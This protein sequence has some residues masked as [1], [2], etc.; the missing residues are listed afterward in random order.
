[1]FDIE[2]LEGGIEKT[3]DT[4]KC[5]VKD[6]KVKVKKM[7]NKVKGGINS[8]LL[9]KKGKLKEFEKYFCKTHKIFISP[10]TFI[11]KNLEDN[12]LWYDE[13]DKALVK[14]ILKVKRVKYQLFYYNSEDA[15]S[16]N[17]FR[18][19][20]KNKLLNAF[21]TDLIN[22]TVKNTEVIYW[23]YSQSQNDVWSEL[24]KARGEFREGLQRSSEPDLIVK[25]DFA[26]F[27]IESKILAPN[28][29]DFN[30]SHTDEEKKERIAR[31]RRGNRFIS[32]SIETIINA[33]Y[34]QLMRFWLI[35]SWIAENNDLDFYLL[36]LVRKNDDKN[37]E[38]YFGKFLTLNERRLFKRI[39]WSDIYN[40]IS[41]NVYSGED[42]DKMLRYFRNKTIYDKKGRLQKAFSIP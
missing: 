6:C 29:V 23:S 31:Y 35:G 15:S 21:L 1:M 8:Y 37:I 27:F 42:K 20:E 3:N 4:V 24:A 5:P 41:K 16:L 12:L 10:T 17:V 18:Y 19:L 33:G 2:E 39:T 14:E 34:Y 11:Y 38:S 36:N 13:D 7:N 9:T 26:L 25:S 22:S 28:I 30:R 40:Y 32:Q